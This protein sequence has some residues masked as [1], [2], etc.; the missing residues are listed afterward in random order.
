MD[1]LTGIKRN[2]AVLLG[3]PRDNCIHDSK[4]KGGGSLLGLDVLPS[5]ECSGSTI[6]THRKILIWKYGFPD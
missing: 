6:V 5:A 4:G 3:V 2:A 1:K